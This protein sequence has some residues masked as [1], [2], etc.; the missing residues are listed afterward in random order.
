MYLLLSTDYSTYVGSTINLEKRLR[1][2]NKEISGGAVYTTNKILNN[3]VWIR[4]MH[5]KGFP[6]WKSA[7]Q[8][9]W[10]WK[11]LSRNISCKHSLKRRMIALKQLINDNKSTK[12]SIP[13][14]EWNVPCEIIFEDDET[15][16]IYTNIL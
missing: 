8:F 9:E 5:V 10:K 11:F 16:K 6:D 4:V 3:N 12:K 7:L 15:K 14:S 1:Q 13:Y 2:H